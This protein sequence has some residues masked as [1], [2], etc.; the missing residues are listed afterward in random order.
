[1]SCDNWNGDMPKECKP[2]V[3]P[4]R[5]YSFKEGKCYESNRLVG[6]VIFYDGITLKVIYNN[7]SFADGTIITFKAL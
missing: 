1:M 6:D 2:I 5:S 7:G 3:M 4:K